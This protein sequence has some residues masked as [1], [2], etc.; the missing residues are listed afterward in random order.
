MSDLPE[1]T[2]GASAV[3]A[4]AYGPNA[5]IGQLKKK[6]KM[7][8]KEKGITHTEALNIVAQELKFRSWDHLMETH[9]NSVKEGKYE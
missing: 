3:L 7:L 4:M 8:K 2:V 6:A 1:R 9:N 5:L